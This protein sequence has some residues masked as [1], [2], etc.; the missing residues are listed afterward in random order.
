M[1]TFGRK[2]PSAPWITSICRRPE[3]LAE[4][5]QLNPESRQ[6]QRGLARVALSNRDD[7]AA[8]ELDKSLNL[9]RDDV[10]TWLLGELELSRGNFEASLSAFKSAEQLLATA[11]AV[12]VGIARTTWPRSH[13]RGR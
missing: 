3:N 9:N 12:R 13:C 4:G 11:P 1:L 6:A 2:G 7:T 5:T 10:Q 8:K